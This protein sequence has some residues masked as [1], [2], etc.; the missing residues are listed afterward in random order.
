MLL[1]WIPGIYFA[2]VSGG[3]L[4]LLIGGWLAWMFFFVA[5]IPQVMWEDFLKDTKKR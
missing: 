2:M 5:K 3:I 1:L 4:G